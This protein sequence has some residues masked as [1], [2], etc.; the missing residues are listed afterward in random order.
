M[1]AFSVGFFVTRSNSE[2]ISQVIQNNNEGEQHSEMQNEE[3]N[4]NTEVEMH[5]DSQ[6]EV[7]KEIIPTNNETPSNRRNKH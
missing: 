4:N 2:K 3:Q 7:S 1:L 5:I 6:E